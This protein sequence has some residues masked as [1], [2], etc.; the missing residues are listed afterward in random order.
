MNKRI[1][2]MG[3]ASHIAHH[4]IGGLTVLN[5]PENLMS[6]KTAELT[7]GFKEL[8]E[9]EV[10]DKQSITQ[11]T[12]IRKSAKVGRND[13]CPCGSLKKYKNCCTVK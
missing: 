6:F 9:Q 7:K 2:V 3:L 4:G 13:A 10:K 1:L 8:R 12:Y 5:D 11:E